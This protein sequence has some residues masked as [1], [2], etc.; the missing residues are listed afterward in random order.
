VQLPHSTHRR[1][2]QLVAE[3]GGTMSELCRTWVEEALAQHFG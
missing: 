2:K 1:F 3:Q